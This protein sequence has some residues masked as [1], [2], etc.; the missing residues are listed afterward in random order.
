MA[1]QNSVLMAFMCLYDLNLNKF[2]NEAPL[3]PWI[4]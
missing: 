3:Y 4:G 1:K 2:S